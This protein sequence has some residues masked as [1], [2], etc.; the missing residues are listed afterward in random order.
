[1]II[2]PNEQQTG[3]VNSAR[4]AWRLPRLTCWPGLE[5]DMRGQADFRNNTENM[6][7]FERTLSSARRAQR[8]LHR[9]LHGA[10]L[11][12]RLC[13][14]RGGQISAKPSSRVRY[15]TV[16]TGRNVY[17]LVTKRAVAH[18]KATMEWVDCNLGS[19]LTMSTRRYTCSGRSP[20]RDPLDRLRRRWPA[21]GRRWQD[22]PRRPR[23]TSSIF[24]KSISKEAAGRPT[25]ACSRSPTG[26]PSPVPRWS[27]TR[28]CSTRT[29]ARTPTHDPHRRERRRVGHEATVSKIGD[30]QLFYLQSRGLD[31]EEASKMIVNGVIEPVTK[32]RPMETRSAEPAD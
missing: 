25:A 32:E 27:A 7:E 2:P 17:N 22:H 23:T 10:G 19:K 12:E 21:P 4:L 29:P 30:E 11:L 3:G 8:P 18:E 20:W 26:R 31:E 5:V 6:G 1:M 9:G 16:Q 15:T 14:L 13:A 28:C 24:S